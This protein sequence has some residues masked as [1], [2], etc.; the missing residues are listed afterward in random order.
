LSHDTP[1]P[2]SLLFERAVSSIAHV[3]DVTEEAVFAACSRGKPM[4]RHCLVYVLKNKGLS[5]MEI[6][7]FLPDDAAHNT[8]DQYRAWERHMRADN[9]LAAKTRLVLERISEP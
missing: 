9:V 3:F 6:F 8:L 2:Q 7:G 1:D 4:L 5:H